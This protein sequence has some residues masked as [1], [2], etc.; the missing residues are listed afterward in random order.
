[1]GGK[2]KAVGSVEGVA[3]AAMI[4]FCV[5]VGAGVVALRYE[6]SGIQKRVGRRI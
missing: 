6:G 1:M 4:G 3:C 2:A 5:G